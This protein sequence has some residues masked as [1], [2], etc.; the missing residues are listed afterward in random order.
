MRTSTSS[1]RCATRRDILIVDKR[2]TGTS[3]A[4]DC[5]WNS[6]GR[7]QRSRRDRGLRQAARVEGGALSHGTGRRRHRRRAG[8]IADSRSRFLRRQLRD[9]RR[10]DVRRPSSATGCAA[11]SSTARTRCVPRTSGFRPTGRAGRDG[12]DRVCERSPSCRALGG[13]ST[14]R[15]QSLLDDVR[16]RPISGTAPDSDGIPLKTTV[17]ESQLFLLMTNLGNSPIT[18]RDLDAAARAWF[19]TRRRVAVA[20][21]L[22]RVRHAIRIRR[23]RLQLRAVPGPWSARN[24]RCTTTSRRRPRSDAGSTTARS[25]MRASIGPTSSRRSRSTK[26]WSRTRTSRRSR[27]ASTGRSRCPHT[28]RAMRCRRIRYFRTCRRSCCRAISIP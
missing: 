11:S 27:P 23:R 3:A 4:I 16:R 6:A 5:P 14:W 10:P 21:P 1:I 26:R 22:G 25:K 20:A 18:Y 9:V 17:D 15:I 2:G 13:K 12:L 8:C 7:S 24:T 28:R 19:E